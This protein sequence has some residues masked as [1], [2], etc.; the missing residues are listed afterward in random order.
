MMDDDE[1]SVPDDHGISTTPSRGTDQR[2]DT[3]SIGTLTNS[4]REDI[5]TAFD[6]RLPETEFG[7]IPI[8]ASDERNKLCGSVSATQLW[9]GFKKS[10]LCVGLCKLVVIMA[11]GIVFVTS[12]KKVN[13]N[14]DSLEEQ[15]FSFVEGLYW[16]VVT[17]TTVGFGD[18][19]P[20]TESA[21]I[22]AIFY[23]F[24]SVYVPVRFSCT[25][26]IE[27]R[28]FAYQDV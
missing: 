20:E 10:N 8:V 15:N 9:K 22:F 13:I 14:D 27:K 2:S 11:I 26:C 19:S 4:D 6:D 16:V 17:G 25:F 7:G 24:V 28:G 1:Y 18:F 23:L 21:R 3:L 5:E 12:Y